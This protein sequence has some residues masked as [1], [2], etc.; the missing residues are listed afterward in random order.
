MAP[1]PTAPT[2]AAPK[3]TAP[4]PDELRAALDAALPNVA[5]AMASIAANPNESDYYRRQARKLMRKAQQRMAA[6]PHEAGCGCATCR[7]DIEIPGPAP[8]CNGPTDGQP[9]CMWCGRCRDLVR[10]GELP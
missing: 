8:S 10:A 3:T 2:P 5:A 4:T 1:T 7:P 6:R 9:P